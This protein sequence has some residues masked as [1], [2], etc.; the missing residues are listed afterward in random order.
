MSKTTGHSKS[1]DH[2]PGHLRY[3]SEHRWE[4]NKKLKIARH[5]KEVER[6]KTKLEKRVERI[7]KIVLP[8]TSGGND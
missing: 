5:E 2:R 6:K 8:I 4:N 3:V 7:E 1:P